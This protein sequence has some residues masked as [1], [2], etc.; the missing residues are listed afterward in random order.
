M[1]ALT[2]QIGSPMNLP[3]TI[4]PTL[5]WIFL[6]LAGVL[7]VV[8][9]IGLRTSDGFTKLWP[10]VITLSAMGLSVVFLG[11]SLK[12]LPLGTAYAVWVGIG[13]VGVAALGIWLFE[14]PASLWRIAS[15]MMITFGII[16]LK[17]L[18]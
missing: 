16:G 9:A 4:T 15:M 17:L 1:K 6:V 13:I 10:S 14:E 12:V 2:L 8:W 5:A 3:F 7:E 11:L 18:D